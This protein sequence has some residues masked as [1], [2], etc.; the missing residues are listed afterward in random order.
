MWGA[1]RARCENPKN[2]AYRFYGARGIKVCERWG[3]FQNFVD[4]MGPRPDGAS[5]ERKDN[6]GDYCPENCCWADRQTQGNNTRRNVFV[7]HGGERKTLS[8]WAH[9]LGC[10]M[11][12][13]WQRI[14][15]YGWPADRAIFTPI[16]KCAKRAAA[17]ALL[18]S[19]F[20]SCSMQSEKMFKDG[21]N[22]TGYQYLV[23]QIGSQTAAE[24]SSGAKYASNSEGSFK[25]FMQTMGI[26]FAGWTAASVQKAK[27]IS[28]QVASREIT[29]Q[30]AQQQMAAIQQAELAAKSGAYSE[31]L[32]AGA[33]ATVGPVTPP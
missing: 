23:F 19:V 7:E 2:T 8:Q 21:P 29:K 30:Q 3:N 9:Q 17:V 15:R 25:D 10:D 22:G 5:I 16:R 12:L 13:I 26:A 11:R 14:N 20:A 4:D 24:S 31:A 18:P 27:E 32:G 6:N 1:M 33:E 28:A